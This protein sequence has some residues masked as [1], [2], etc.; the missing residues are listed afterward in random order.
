METASSSE[1]SASYNIATQR[2]KPEE[3]EFS[4][5]VKISN[6]ETNYICLFHI[7]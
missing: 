5:Q 3:L 4:P 1:T 6:L 7:I 2:H